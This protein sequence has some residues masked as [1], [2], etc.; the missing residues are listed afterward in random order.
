MWARSLSGRLQ[1][2]GVDWMAFLEAE[3]VGLHCE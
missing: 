2:T 1:A 3:Q